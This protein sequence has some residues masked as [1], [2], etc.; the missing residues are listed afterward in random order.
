LTLNV[1]EPVGWL[2]IVPTGLTVAVNFTL[3][4]STLEVGAATRTVWLLGGFTVSVREL[5]LP[6]KVESP[7]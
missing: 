2:V 6:P 1:T 3:W 5:E 4:V 7:P